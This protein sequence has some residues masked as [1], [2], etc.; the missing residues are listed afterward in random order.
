MFSLFSFL[1][2]FRLKGEFGFAANMRQIS[3]DQIE[4]FIKQKGLNIIFYA[5]KGS[6]LEFADFVNEKYNSTINFAR[7]LP[8]NLQNKS[9][10]DSFPCVVCYK[11][12]QKYGENA[13][14][15]PSGYM[16]W[17]IDLLSPPILELKHPEEVRT[18]LNK[19]GSFVIGVDTQEKP[20]AMKESET[21]YVVPS[22]L[23]K[24]FFVNVSAGIYVYRSADRMLV[25][26]PNNKYKSYMRTPI[27][28]PL[29]AN[30]SSKKYIAGYFLER[31]NPQSNE[32]D[33]QCLTSLAHKFKHDVHFLPIAGGLSAIFSETIG[34]GYLSFPLFAMLPSGENPTNHYLI[35]GNEA[36]NVTHVS[37]VI[38]S[39]L[40]GKIDHYYPSE[41]INK[42][43]KYQITYNTLNSTLQWNRGWFDTVIAFV[44]P[45]MG[46]G[47][48]FSKLIPC[49]ND[50]INNDNIKFYIYN[51]STNMEPKD[52]VIPNDP[53]VY[54]YPKG[55][56]ESILYT[57][58]PNIKHFIDW[59]CEKSTF[60]PAMPHY[61][62]KH[63]MNDV[64]PPVDKNGFNIKYE[65]EIWGI[66]GE[67]PDPTKQDSTSEL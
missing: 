67:T 17:V 56:N 33:M 65:E 51:L 61:S 44:S 2:I 62:P 19:H 60:N 55:T 22:R 49:V 9:I 15:I 50:L 54:F 3:A 18:L 4:N 48:W 28:D 24:Y 14:L 37:E 31:N 26:A 63:Y 42:S 7:T 23:L 66:P 13:P 25:K 45:Y 11:M 32:M 43:N 5:E 52:I 58:N 10:C 41:T 1:S 64:L 39:V 38:Q 35:Q 57:G 27:I 21:F 12:G 53:V 8:E 36:R 20:K 40:E 6:N 29:L 46:K 30:L 16:D 34:L 59:V 47:D